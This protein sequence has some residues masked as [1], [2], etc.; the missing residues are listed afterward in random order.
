MRHT[1][2]KIICYTG[3]NSRKNGKH[4]VKNFKKLTKKLYPKSKCKEMNEWKKTNPNT[5]EICPKN[6]KA[7]VKFLGASYTTP[8]KCNAMVAPPSIN[9]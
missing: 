5:K 6:T 4:S 1:R 3:I 7:W 8:K 2:K 9:K